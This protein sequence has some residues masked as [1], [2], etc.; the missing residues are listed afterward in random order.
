MIQIPKHKSVI[1]GGRVRKLYYFGFYGRGAKIC[2]HEEYIENIV[3][4]EGTLNNPL[5][6]VGETIYISDIKKDV[7]VVSRSKNTDGGYVY[8]V[9]YQEEIED[10]ATEESLRRATEEEQKYKESEQQRLEKEIED[11]KK[12]KA[13]EE[14]TTTKTKKWYLFWK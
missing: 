3:V 8:F 4:W 9:N 1:I 14:I 11:A 6:D 10:E 13:K 12:E 7:A 5:A 2:T